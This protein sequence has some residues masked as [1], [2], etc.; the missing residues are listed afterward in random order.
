M[1]SLF[2]TSFY[3]HAV[4]RLILPRH[5]KGYAPFLF[6]FGGAERMVYILS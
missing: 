3:Y 4:M 5:L 1:T 6:L 2:V